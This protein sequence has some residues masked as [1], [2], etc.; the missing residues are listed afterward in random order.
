MASRGT[1][2]FVALFTEAFSVA[3]LFVAVVWP[4]HGLAAIHRSNQ[5]Q[6]HRGLFGSV[7]IEDVDREEAFH[8]V[9]VKSLYYIQL[10]KIT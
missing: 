8:C 10:E 6:P 7:N 5:L 4:S 9:K 1:A 3:S 2:F